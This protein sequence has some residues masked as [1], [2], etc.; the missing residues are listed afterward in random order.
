MIPLTMV[1]QR[2]RNFRLTSADSI[3]TKAEVVKKYSGFSINMGI[4]IGHLLYPLYESE[5]FI[6]QRYSN[7]LK[8]GFAFNTEVS[9]HVGK[10]IGAGL[11]YSLHNSWNS[12]DNVVFTYPTG[13]PRQ[14]DLSDNILVQFVGFNLIGRLPF[15]KDKVR[16]QIGLSAGYSSFRNR[17][18]NPDQYTISSETVGVGGTFSLDFR[19]SKA[20]FFGASVNADYASFSYFDLISEQVEGRYSLLHEDYIDMTRIGVLFVVRYCIM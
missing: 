4:G 13:S 2:Q 1:A 10:H 20:V 18:T 19:V 14:G 16:L 9:Y 17:G 12:L 5:T 6:G 7:K 11:R 3:L 8:T 15:K